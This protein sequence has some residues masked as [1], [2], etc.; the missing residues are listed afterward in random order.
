MI[1]AV[2]ASG[3]WHLRTESTVWITPLKLLM[4]LFAVL[5]ISST[6]AG[7][8]IEPVAAELEAQIESVSSI[9]KLKDQTTAFPNAD[10]VNPGDV[11]ADLHCDPAGGSSQYSESLDL[12]RRLRIVVTSQCPN[13]YSFCQQEGCGGSNA[14]L[15]LVKYTRLEMPLYPT[16]AAQ[17]TDGNDAFTLLARRN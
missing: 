15:A 6:T 3:S 7:T 13:H 4:L 9:Y 2:G 17:R 5:S 8:M 14:T 11:P 1:A 10:Q 16:L 12:L